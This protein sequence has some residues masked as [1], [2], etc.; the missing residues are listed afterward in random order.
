MIP[1]KTYFIF[2]LAEQDSAFLKKYKAAP[3]TI[4]NISKVAKDYRKFAEETIGKEKFE[5]KIK[6]LENRFQ[7]RL[8][9]VPIGVVND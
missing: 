5:E 4:G 7:R 2:Q 1:Q 9:R 8:R 6:N 3:V